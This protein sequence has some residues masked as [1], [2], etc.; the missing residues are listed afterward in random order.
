M[1]RICL[2]L[3]FALFILSSVEGQ[4]SDADRDTAL[5][6]LVL[7][8]ASDSRDARIETIDRMART[9]DPRME[10]VLEDFRT[11]RLILHG[12]SMVIIGGEGVY[13]EDYVE[14]IPLSDLLTR[15]PIAGPDGKQIMVPIHEVEKVAASRKERRLISRV[16]PLLRLESKEPDVRLAGVKKVGD[17]PDIR[18]A[19]ERLE[20][21][22]LED[23]VNKIR[24]VAHE[25]L[26]LMQLHAS[27]QSGSGDSAIT[28]IN[29]L[30]E[31]KSIRALPRLAE[32]LE[33]WPA[34]EDKA[35]V[36]SSIQTTIGIIRDHQR[37]VKAVNN[38]YQGLSLGSVLIFM[39]LGLAITFGLMG[40][41]NM[42]HGELMMIGAY[43]TYE[44][45]R[46]IMYLIDQGALTEKAFDYYYIL[47]L[48]ASFFAAALV[49]YVIELLVIR[50]LYRRPI[51]SLL[52]TWGI[53]LILI[54]LVRIQ[55]GDN[56]GV[57]APSWARGGME[58]AQD[59][60]LP[61]GRTYVIAL[62]A[63]SIMMI[64]ALM[65]RTRIGLLMRSTM[66]NRD[67]ANSLGVNTGR[68]DRF[69]FALGSGIAGIAGY[70]WTLIGG[71]TPDMGQKNFIVDSFLIVVTGGVGNLA[72]VVCSGLGIGI[73]TK[74][75]EPAEIGG[76]PVG[77][78]WA[79]VIVL[80]L[81]VTFIQFKP[82]G[83]FAPKGRTADV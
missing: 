11:G 73:T 3:L 28:A 32:V 26:A 47:A 35:Q 7:G 79:K 45:Q 42:A 51:E 5:R 4:E 33:E 25:S 41:I 68:I 27:R 10:V 65:N 46:F 70:A 75:I 48:P 15:D 72:G 12:G 50:H 66:Q 71:V 63:F 20:I 83:L 60:V 76:N 17:S 22:A 29:K 44:M 58:V 43:A 62:C 37:S 6:E 34:G 52:A 69:T 18:G 31:L 40:V 49:G 23:D 38:I 82:A 61:Y 39:A 59:I 14:Y 13:D 9:S 24:H 55:Y 54:Q 16:R 8:L 21:I 53:G 57:N 78:I 19:R 30:G 56:I 80:V 74:I 36:I 67:M 81:I 77:A 1:A 2:S 64:W